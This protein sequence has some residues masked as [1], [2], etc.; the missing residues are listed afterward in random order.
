MQVAGC[1]NARR[2]RHGPAVDLTFT[3]SCVDLRHAPNPRFD[4]AIPSLIPRPDAIL[5]PYQFLPPPVPRT[6][7]TSTTPICTPRRSRTSTTRSTMVRHNSNERP[8]RTS[9]TSPF[10]LPTLSLF[11]LGLPALSWAFDCKEI[12]AS[13][14]NF[15]FEKLGGP[16]VLHWEEEPDIDHLLQ[17]KYNFTLDICQK[18]AWHKGGSLATEC[19]HGTRSM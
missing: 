13:K 19:H 10:S 18:L 16:H 5:P 11:L 14:T 2:F 3:S 9:S 15:N 17:Y 8:S 7:P 1:C 6:P 12:L 4:S